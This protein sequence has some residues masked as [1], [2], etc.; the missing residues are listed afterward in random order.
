[1]GLSFCQP[2]CNKRNWK[3]TAN[4]T[5]IL[6][7][8]TILY[9]WEIFTPTLN[10]EHMCL[11]WKRTRKDT[12]AFS[13]FMKIPSPS[14]STSRHLKYNTDDTTIPPTIQNRFI[15]VREIYRTYNFCEIPVEQLYGIIFIFHTNE[16]MINMHE[17]SKFFF[18][19]RYE[20]INNL[21]TFT[22]ILS[23]SFFG[24]PL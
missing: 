17:G 8:S 19:L 1:M 5:F 24:S 23:S 13:S 3:A 14:T 15:G 18:C 10:W 22:P 7:K 12:G 2:K 6:L 21:K 16:F 9:R 20:Y 11:T 4:Q